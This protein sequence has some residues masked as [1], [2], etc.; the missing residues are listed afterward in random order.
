MS[1]W[2]YVFAMQNPAANYGFCKTFKKAC[3]TR[4]YGVLETWRNHV[5]TRGWEQQPSEM[6]SKHYVSGTSAQSNV[7]TSHSIN[8]LLR[9]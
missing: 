8:I 1:I 9:F 3:K 7:E 4:G 6:L 5:Q 2:T